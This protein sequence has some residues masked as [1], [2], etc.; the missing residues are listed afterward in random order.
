MR[1]KAK[2]EWLTG[3]AIG[4]LI[5]ILLFSKLAFGAELSYEDVALIEKTVQAEAGNQSIE[6][7]RY[8]AAVIINRVE[9]PAFPDTVEGVLEQEGQFSTYKHLS[10]AEATWQDELATKMEIE[11]RSNT[12]IVFFRAGHY[13]CG[14]PAFQCGDHYFSTKK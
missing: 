3:I 14:Q 9:D 2:E 5:G 13:G 8:V 6:G 1:K 10:S 4:L 11:S 7:R 12:D